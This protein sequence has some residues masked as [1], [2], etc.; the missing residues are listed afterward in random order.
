MIPFFNLKGY[1]N[2]DPLDAPSSKG[3]VLHIATAAVIIPLLLYLIVYVLE[4][5][6]FKYD[7]LFGI[8]CISIIFIYTPIV[9]YLRKSSSL[10]IMFL[11]IV[12]G[13][14][15][16]LY[17]DS[18][19][20]QIGLTGLWFYNN[21]SIIGS[22]QPLLKIEIVWLVDSLLFGPF[23]LWI[24]RLVASLLKLETITLF[25][26]EMYDS[27]FKKEWT[28]EFVEKPVYDF[29]F[30]I[31]RITGFVY[32]FYLVL[33]IISS[34]GINSYPAMIKD[35]LTMTYENP[36]LTINTYIKVVMMMT[37]CFTGAF[38][39]ELRFHSTL[40]LFVA[41][42]TSTIGGLFF[43]LYDSPETVYRQYLLAS[44][45]ADGALCILFLFVMVKYKNYASGFSIVK[46]FP[47]YYSLANRLQKIFYYTFAAIISIIVPGILFIRLFGDGHSVFGAV[48]GF[49]DPQVTNT[50]TKYT[51]IAFLAFLIADREKLRAHLYK[52]LL[53]G[54]TTSVIVSGIWLLIGGFFS[55]IL[56]KTRHN[57]VTTEDWYFM[58]NVLL[59]GTVTTL[60]LLFRKV[61]YHVENNITSLSPSNAQNAMAV[62][63]ALY[64][65][66]EDDGSQVIQSIDRHVS[67]IRGRKRGLLNFPFWLIENVFNI[68]Y[69]FYPSY[70]SMDKQNRKYFLRRYLLRPLNERAKS[71][72]PI[73]TEFSYKISGAVHAL[74]T[75][76]HYN[77]L[78]NKEKIGFVPVEAR[79]RL[80]GD[81]NITNAPFSRTSKLPKS[82]NEPENF[83][84]DSFSSQPL[85]SNRIVTAVKE[86][87]LPA[88]IDYLVIGS[89]AGGA[90]MTYRLASEVNDPSKIL[91]V[92]RGSRFSP[93]QDFNDNEMEMIGKL[94]KE[95]GL[96]QTKK[97]DLIV[98]Q[99][100]CLGGTTVINNGIC[101]KL[102]TFI[103]QRWQD[104][105][106]INLTDIDAEYDKIAKEIDI[107][108]I[109]DN[110]INQ[111]VKQK[112]IDGVTGL[113]KILSPEQKLIDFPI[114][115]NHRNPL[116]EGLDNIGNKRMRKRSMLETY[117]P[118]SEARGVN[119][120]SNWSAVRF[121]CNGRHA[122]EVLFRSNI[123]TL[124]RVRVNKAVIVA[125]GT[126]ASS[127]FL[128]RSDIKENVG[129][130]LS[131]NF[132]FPVAFKFSEE[133]KAF[134]GLQITLGALDP[135]SRGAF[136]TYFNPPASFSISLPFYF[137]RHK[138]TMMSYNKLANFG[139]LVGSEPN[140]NVE[141]KPDWINGR[142]FNWNFGYK[143]KENIKYALSTLIKMGF[144]AGAESAIIPTD[145]GI[146]LPLN[147]KNINDFCRELLHYPLNIND[148]HLTTAHPQGGNKMAGKNSIHKKSRVINENYKLEGFE[149]VFV[150]DA[151][152]FPT[153]ITINP[154][155][156]IM[157][158]SSLA[159]KKVL[160][161]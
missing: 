143:D 75:I 144:Y 129:H 137:N 135:Q 49:P 28:N 132:A 56:I 67:N 64:G 71:Y 141:L 128:L 161:T 109:P 142:A 83:K 41:H 54:Y 154:Q 15:L 157:A 4:V 65:G 14:P 2:R 127:H 93:L 146:E 43:F 17:I 79:D 38:N 97:F 160:E 114:Q 159:S 69:G 39:F 102:P 90:V 13:L 7:W 33:L 88:E 61:Y 91:L 19:Y 130:G 51:T 24:A 113:N 148:L 35:F 85:I 149:N 78:G 1:T 155:W 98:L 62:H 124:K 104:E 34:L 57:T 112:F 118:W 153:G 42:M 133:L 53:M 47:E 96:Q 117:I 72:F 45:I 101:V 59:D 95:G 77:Q 11:L 9:Y 115:S 151:S 87:P 82:D 156:T 136:E 32:L 29:S 3:L 122:K 8:E 147:E 81:F 89:G 46:E 99:G 121:I 68:L 44:A 31:L 27:F 20:R 108:P 111:K 52:P 21:D 5:A 100:E 80:A 105:F 50:I 58:L 152:I 123:G 40:V 55:D 18:N 70:S 139:A 126:I 23:V 94:Y 119:V 125:G 116:G 134:D 22:L 138:T 30:Y 84:A 107:Q 25:S 131:C 60:I 36:P 6:S 10:L 86:N 12:I 92:E 76:A 140:G 26:K 63:D 150:A 103:R 73:L 106:D 74:V 48:Y 120:V 158:M 145:P 66:S 16:D 37:I 110:V